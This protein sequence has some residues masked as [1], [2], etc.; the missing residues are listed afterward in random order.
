MNLTDCKTIEEYR[1]TAHYWQKKW[2]EVEA[3]YQIE[4][5]E[6]LNCKATILKLQ[7]IIKQLNIELE[8]LCS[9]D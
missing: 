6:H 5:Q 3:E 9:D 4:K 7:K 8:I 1:E 2:A